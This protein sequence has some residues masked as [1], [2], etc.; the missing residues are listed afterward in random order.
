MHPRGRKDL[1]LVGLFATR[2]P[3]RPNPIGISVVRLIKV[4]KNLLTV[5][6][7]DAIDGTPVLDVKPYLPQNDRI[8]N[9]VIPEWAQVL[10]R[11][12]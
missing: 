3:A 7:L 1:P 6:G 4:D 5:R 2:S 10:A 11:E 9:P 12:S 8:E